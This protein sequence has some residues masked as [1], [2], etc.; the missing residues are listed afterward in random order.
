MAFIR[1]GAYGAGHGVDVSW[2]VQPNE[3]ELVRR[4]QKCPG[5][6]VAEFFY[7]SVGTAPADSG[8]PKPQM[9][10]LMEQGERPSGFSI[11][12]IDHDEG[13]DLI[14]E[15]ETTKRLDVDSCVVAAEIAD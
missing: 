1:E 2:L 11:L 12:V 13:G 9:R 15:R 14:R 4:K 5:N 10:E 7:L 8:S 3:S 6:F